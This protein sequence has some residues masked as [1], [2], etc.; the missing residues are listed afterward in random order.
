M[1]LRIIDCEAYNNGGDGIRLGSNVDAHIE[2]FRASGN[3]GHAIN[4]VGKAKP[5]TPVQRSWHERPAGALALGLLAGVSVE[6]LKRG[7]GLP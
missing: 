6:A 1:T 3:G 4:I 2:R 7:L 5:S